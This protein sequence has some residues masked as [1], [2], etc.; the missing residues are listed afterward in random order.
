MGV[1]R[2]NPDDVTTLWR[3]APSRYRILFVTVFA[4][5]V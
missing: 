3:G 5:I 4:F 2:R 1:W